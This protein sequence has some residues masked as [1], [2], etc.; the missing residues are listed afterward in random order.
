MGSPLESPSRTAPVTPGDAVTL[1]TGRVSQSKRQE[2]AFR[3]LRHS[4]TTVTDK[5]AIACSF[6][7][8]AARRP[9]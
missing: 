8:A 1:D 7:G 6:A 5:P 3:A 4:V 9:P 2:D